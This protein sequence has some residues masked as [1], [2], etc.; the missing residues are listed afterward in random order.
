MKTSKKKIKNNKSTHVRNE[1]THHDP[2]FL[3][4]IIPYFNVM[5]KYFRYEVVGLEHIPIGKRSLVVMNHGIIPYH[6]F[7]LCKKVIERRKVYPRG[8]AAGFLFS[9]P[10]VRDFFLKGGAVNANPKNGERLLKNDQCLFLAPGG[11]YEGLVCEPG[12]KRI[13]WERRKGFVRLALQTRTPIIPT[14]CVGIND[15]YWNSRLFL[16]WRIKI[17]EAIRFSLPLFY[18]LG[19]APLPVKLTHF[20]GKPIPARIKSGETF[21]QAVK[22]IHTQVMDAMKELAQ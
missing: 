7:L 22:R 20:V 16:K 11:I 14:F 1:L 2:S 8:L 6:G 4:K 10:L 13:P 3:N 9:I 21:E 17:L 12:M 18:G 19:L 15:V 5:E